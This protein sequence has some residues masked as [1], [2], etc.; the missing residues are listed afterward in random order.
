MQNPQDC[1]P[2]LPDGDKAQNPT[3]ASDEDPPT[4]TPEVEALA[5][6]E[7]CERDMATRRLRCLDS[8]ARRLYSAAEN[9]LVRVR[10]A[11]ASRAQGGAA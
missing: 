1:L 3:N 8:V 4:L 9:A 10:K 6:I 7:A 11:N 5:F 2:C